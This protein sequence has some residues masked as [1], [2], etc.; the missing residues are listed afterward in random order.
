MNKNGT[1]PS[2]SNATSYDNWHHLKTDYE[3]ENSDLRHRI[4][5]NSG[6]QIQV[7]VGKKLYWV[8]GNYRVVD[9]S[10]RPTTLPSEGNR[11]P[12]RFYDASERQAQQVYYSQDLRRLWAPKQTR[13][14]KLAQ[15]FFP[16]IANR[17]NHPK[18]ASQ[19]LP[20]Y[21]HNDCLNSALQSVA[22]TWLDTGL[23]KDMQQ[24]SNAIP[25]SVLHHMVKQLSPPQ[26]TEVM[27]KSAV[28]NLE[29]RQVAVDD[30][31]GL[32]EAIKSYGE[33]RTTFLLLCRGLN[34]QLTADRYNTKDLYKK[35]LHAYSSYGQTLGMREVP[36]ILG[37]S[38]G[39]GLKLSRIPQQ[40]PAAFLTSL[41]SMFGFNRNPETAITEGMKTTYYRYAGDRAHVQSARVTPKELMTSSVSI[42]VSGGDL[43]E[44]LNNYLQKPHG[45]Q[46][47]NPNEVTRSCLTCADGGPPKLLRLDIDL[48]GPQGPDGKRHFQQKEGKA[49]LSTHIPQGLTVPIMVKTPAG[50]YSEMK[51]L[52]KITDM[53]FLKNGS[54]TQ[55]N[56]FT[57]RMLDNGLIEIFNNGRVAGLNDYRLNKCHSLCDSLEDFCRKEKLVCVSVQMKRED[58][59]LG[60]YDWAPRVPN[61]ATTNRLFV[62]RSVP[63]SAN[64]TQARY[65]P[66]YPNR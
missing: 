61:G 62:Q 19:G 12:S 38:P 57:A 55:G 4:E 39:K 14:Q 16:C 50:N 28:S 21:G 58:S 8:D 42:P 45:Q 48:S 32:S 64:L 10:S 29:R 7:Q 53:V 11:R 20:H 49:L 3:N 1:A 13:C 63:A 27:I 66:Y 18:M 17:P 60:A 54:P 52:Y 25:S 15:R 56:Y 35:F 40:D 43:Q 6:E 51:Q 31:P 47:Q 24:S 23:L 33:L 37:M 2:R 34:G 30:L 46:T 9:V 44:C 36:H 22:K 5:S 65:R 26:T 41:T 59:S